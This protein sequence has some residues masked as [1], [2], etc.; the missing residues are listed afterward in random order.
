MRLFQFVGELHC[1]KRRIPHFVQ[2]SDAGPLGVL[3]CGSGGTEQA[4]TLH[5]DAKQSTSGDAPRGPDPREI[6]Q[7]DRS[8]LLPAGAN[9]GFE[10][11]RRRPSMP[12]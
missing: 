11:L 12:R 9:R 1:G 5:F 6:G 3:R 4:F 7:R 10:R 2:Q 8:W